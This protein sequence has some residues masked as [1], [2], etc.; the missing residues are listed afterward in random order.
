MEQTRSIA[1]PAVFETK[2]L[3]LRRPHISD[4]GDIFA[5]Y[6]SDPEVTRYVT[7]LPYNDQNE[8]APFLQSRLARWDSGE[9]YSWLLTLT[10]NDRAI[11]MI[12]CRAREHA[13]DIGYVLGRACWGRGYATEAAIA[14]VEWASR[15]ATIYRVW[16]VCDVE[17]KASARVLEKVGMQREGMLRRYIIHPNV[18]AEPRDC[19]VYAKVR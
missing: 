18:S 12:G 8:V 5:N 19:F 1:P 6:A 7:W 16:A 11:G 2:R 10:G 13:A 14:I 15:L 4:A 3:I 9:E 17:N